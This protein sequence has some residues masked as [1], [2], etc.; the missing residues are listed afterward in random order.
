MRVEAFHKKMAE[1][2]QGL[3]NQLQNAQEYHIDLRN[4]NGKFGM[5][6][7][8]KILDTTVNKKK[9]EYSGLRQSLDRTSK[10]A[11]RAMP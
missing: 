8:K 9:A 11:G 10:I 5:G 7:L 2:L 1:F 4:W 6:N 3:L